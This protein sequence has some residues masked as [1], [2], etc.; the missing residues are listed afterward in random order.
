[1]KK[2]P[3]LRS[4]ILLSVCL[5][6]AALTACKKE[7]IATDGSVPAVFT[8]LRDLDGDGIPEMIVGFDRNAAR[9]L[10]DAPIVLEGFLRNRSLVI[11]SDGFFIQH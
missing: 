1:M 6:L 4:L 10:P 9:A 5:C 8:E 7:N 3:N 11:E 2:Q